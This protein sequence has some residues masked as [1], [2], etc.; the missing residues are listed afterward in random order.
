MKKCSEVVNVTVPFI[1]SNLMSLLCLTSLI[2]ES[3]ERRF[4]VLE[5]SN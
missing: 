3:G 1:I 5:Q 4:N 2:I